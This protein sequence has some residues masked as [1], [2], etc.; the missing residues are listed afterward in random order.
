MSR[1]EFLSL[2]HNGDLKRMCK[3]LHLSVKGCKV[4]ADYVRII[5]KSGWSHPDGVTES[6][7]SDAVPDSDPCTKEDSKDC[8]EV[9]SG[10]DEDDDSSD[11][12]S[13]SGPDEGGDDEEDRLLWERFVAVENWSD[14]VM[15]CVLWLCDLSSPGPPTYPLLRS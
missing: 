7:L 6:Q 15:P 5:L 14:L 10:S 2:L 11:E 3:D 12:D 8:V 13:G 4:K 9:D 1:E